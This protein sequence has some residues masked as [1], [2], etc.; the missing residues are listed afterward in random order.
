M[1]ELNIYG[2]YVPILLIQAVIAYVLLRILM[3][4]LDR[5]IAN[6]WI[7]MPNI[8]YLCIYVLLLGAVHWAGLLL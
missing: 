6:D 1:G 5:L 7:I 2:V 4:W 3:K 8:F